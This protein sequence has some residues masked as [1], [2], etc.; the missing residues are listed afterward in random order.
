MLFLTASL[1]K[2]LSSYTVGRHFAKILDEFYYGSY[3]FEFQD[4]WH[5][6]LLHHQIFWDH[7]CGYQ[8]LLDI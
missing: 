1:L 2:Y 8:M 5:H 4:L 7:L 3:K 6:P